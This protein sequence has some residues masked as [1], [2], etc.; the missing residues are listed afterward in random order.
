MVLVQG[1][2][3]VDDR[4]LEANRERYWEESLA[5][6]PDTKSMHPPKFMRGMFD[7]YYTRLYVHVRPERV[8]VWPTA[9]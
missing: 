3:H 9:T 5:K 8:Y 6:L 7:W 1:T 2:A 4:D